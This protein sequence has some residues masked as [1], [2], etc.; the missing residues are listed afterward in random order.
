M[1]DL[2]TRPVIREFIGDYLPLN[3]EIPFE[4][5]EYLVALVSPEVPVSDRQRRKE[6]LLIL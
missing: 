6:G 1:S 3:R 4:A 5:G 2:L